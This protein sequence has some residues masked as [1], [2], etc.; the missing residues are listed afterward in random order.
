MEEGGR[1]KGGKEGSRIGE[2]GRGVGSD[3]TSRTY[4]GGNVFTEQL[5]KR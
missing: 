4:T 2:C 3:R 1:V 5:K